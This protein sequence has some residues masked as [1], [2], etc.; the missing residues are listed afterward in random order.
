ML[1]ACSAYLT[2][3]EPMTLWRIN[4]VGEVAKCSTFSHTLSVCRIWRGLGGGKMNNLGAARINVRPGDRMH[5]ACL[6]KRLGF[7][8]AEKEGALGD[9]PRTSCCIDIGANLS[10]SQNAVVVE[11][12]R[13]RSCRLVNKR[14]KTSLN[15]RSRPAKEVLQ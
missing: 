6:V 4:F 9:K 1:V 11:A 7:I 12:V 8:D 3:C 13:D 10:W 15:H 2:F 14:Q 5:V